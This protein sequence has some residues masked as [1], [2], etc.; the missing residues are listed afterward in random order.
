[1]IP[2]TSRIRSVDVL[3]GL[4]CVL[5]AIDHVRV[6]SGLPPG[7]PDAG[8][9]FTRWITHFVAPAFCFFAGT[10]AFFLG[11]KLGDVKPLARY[12]VTRGMVLILLELTLVRFAWTFNADYGTYL[13]GGILW[14]LGICMILM[15][16]LV[17]FSTWSIGLFGF[18]VIF[19]QQLV[20]LLATRV[21]R[22]SRS[23]VRWIFQ[24][25]YTGGPIKF[26]SEGPTF[27]ILYSIIPWI[28]VM[29]IGYAFGTVLLRE[30]AERRRWCV[31]AGLA[32]TVAFLV[33]ATVADRMSVLN[34]PELSA[35]PRFL[36]RLLNQ[37]K[38]PA[39]PLFLLMT[40]GP[41]I[42][43]VPLAESARGWISDALETFGRV[44]MFYYILHIPLIHLTA[45]LISLAR[46]GSV[47]PWLFANHPVMSPRA[48]AGYTWSLG[49]L[50]LVWALLL[51]VLYV[52]CRWYAGIK[53]KNPKGLLRYI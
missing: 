6:Y 38:Y 3:R 14:M 23:A 24:V 19:A 26:G 21:P 31:R 47:N 53:A 18:V 9:F 11:R 50:Y 49:L 25:L 12:L 34:R 35:D 5:M 36:F 28:G 22:G 2:T 48:P 20:V 17:R 37:Q 32:A 42:A 39:S 29:A 15:G 43:L 41:L 27:A 8:I 4:A 33:F 44:P 52:A 16:G 45:L 30:P 10:G 13:L 46:E 7:G 40:L 1:M 51:P